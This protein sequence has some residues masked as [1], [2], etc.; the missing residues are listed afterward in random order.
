MSRLFQLTA[1]LFVLLLSGCK[2]SAPVST[3]RNTTYSSMLPRAIIYKVDKRYRDKVPVA[4][5][6]GKMR[7]IS[8]PA[9]TDV[10]ESTAPIELADGYLLDRQGVGVNTV[11]LEWTRDE[12]S[13]MHATPSVAAIKEAII[14]M[15]YVSVLVELPMTTQEAAADIEYVNSLIKGGLKDLKIIKGRP[16]QIGDPP[17]VGTRL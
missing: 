8:F 2:S 12:Y 1:F 15:S 9:P 17:V 16:M 13:A 5:D 14:P 3:A 4:M 7:L 11:F 6:G 10:R